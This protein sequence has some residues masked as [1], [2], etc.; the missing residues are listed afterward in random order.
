[1]QTARSALCTSIVNGKIYAI[2]GWATDGGR[3]LATVEAYDPVT[4]TWTTK[5][6]MP[7]GRGALCCAAV[8]G[9]I[10]VIGGCPSFPNCSGL[11]IVEEYTPVVTSVEN[12]TI[13]KPLTF[14]LYQNYPNP[15]NP[16]TQIRY[17]IPKQSH[18]KLKIIDILGQEIRTLVN[19]EKPAG[20]YQVT[21]SAKDNLGHPAPTGI[22]CY[23]LTTEDFCYM[24]KMAMVK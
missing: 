8:N 1:M 24:R 15:F 5:T 22:Y 16:Q 18:V 14:V 21:W 20:V 12:K 4:D 19:D 13:K 3:K 10:Y 6:D 9:K 23:Q 7:T 11:K 2:G 17:E